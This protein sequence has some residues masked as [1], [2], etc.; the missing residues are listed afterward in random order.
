MLKTVMYVMW[1]QDD[2]YQGLTFNLKMNK[3][4]VQNIDI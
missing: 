4:S 3:Q 1:K 2:T